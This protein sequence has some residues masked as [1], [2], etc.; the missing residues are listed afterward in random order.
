MTVGPPRS[1]SRSAPGGI[2]NCG[3][4]SS[5]LAP[6]NDVEGMRV[7]V[8]VQVFAHDERVP[9]RAE[10]RLQVGDR[11]TRRGVGQVELQMTVEPGNEGRGVVA[12]RRGEVVDRLS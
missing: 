11:L 8:L 4:S 2:S 12:D 6:G 10:V 1:F 9:E 5:S 3:I 7:D